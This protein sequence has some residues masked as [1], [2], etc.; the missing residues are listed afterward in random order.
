MRD[1]ER[2][3]PKALG[4]VRGNRGCE[5][6]RSTSF[7][8]H[9]RNRASHVTAEARLYVAGGAHGGGGFFD[10]CGGGPPGGFWGAPSAPPGR[11]NAGTG[12]GQAATAWGES[13]VH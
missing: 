7:P 6:E 8:F 1:N 2:D 11:G 9:Y 5:V 13:T 10:F 12:G 4:C 3:T